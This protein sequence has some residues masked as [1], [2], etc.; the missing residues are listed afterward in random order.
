MACDTSFNVRCNSVAF[1]PDGTLYSAIAVDGRLLTV[2]P[3]HGQ[4][5]SVTKSGAISQVIDISASEGHIVPTS[6]AARDRSSHR[7]AVGADIDHF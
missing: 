7:A 1:E 6:I 4:V 3:D 2:E 5:I